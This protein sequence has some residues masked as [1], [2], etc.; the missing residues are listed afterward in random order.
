MFAFGSHCR[1][2]IQIKGGMQKWWRQKKKPVFLA[3]FSTLF[4]AV[5]GEIPGGKGMRLG[6]TAV[7]L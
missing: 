6:I 4:P 1:E 2:I 7:S 3:Q 5:L